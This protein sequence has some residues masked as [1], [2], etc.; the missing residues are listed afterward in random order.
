MEPKTAG[1][2]IRKEVRFAVVM[3]GGVSLAIYINGVVQELFRMVRATAAD[4]GKGDSFLLLPGEKLSGTERVYRK[5][6]RMLGREGEEKGKS[7]RPKDP[8]RTNFV[9]DIL[10]GSS[11]GGINAVYLA[12]A[13]ANGQDIGQLSELWIDEGDIA[14][15]IND[16][17]SRL[18][19]LEPQK[20]PRSLLNGQRMYRKLLEALDGME[21]GKKSEAEAKSPYVE[22]LDLFVTA[23]DF[24]GLPV[25]L[26]LLGKVVEELR[27]RNV[28]QLRYSSKLGEGKIQNDFLAEN[29]PFLAFVARST[30]AFPFAFD[31]IKMTDTGNVLKTMPAYRRQRFD[32]SRWQRFFPVYRQPDQDLPFSERAFVDGGYLDNKPFSYAI[33]ALA[34]RSSR[35]PVDRKLIY[36][37]P[38][39]EHIEDQRRDVPNAI[40]NA[41]AA[42]SS[43]PRYE[44]IREDLQR[45]LHRNRLVE[46]MESINSNVE[47]DVRHGK[48]RKKPVRD[49]RFGEQDLK[50]MIAVE[51]VAYGGYHRL[52]VEAVSDDIVGM[53]SS[54]AEFDVDSDEFFAVR[55]L[56]RAW[57]KSNYTAYLEEDRAKMTENEFLV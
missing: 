52:K 37:E 1:R 21:E 13:L 6:G 4:P 51:G 39:P 10:S 55:Y 44:P 2:E 48:L 27:H 49:E 56:V 16:E 24:Y 45:L 36:V 20:P 11:A 9:V 50:K 7:L 17:G 34:S 8:V 22:A 54:S 38:S 19:G 30:S 26:R 42:L 57:R 46:R 32:W 41:S 15:L 33:D 5:L 40:E 18:N 29:N 43:L 35:V 53:I 25:P 3:Y 14:K 28:Y 23:T 31:P 47:E 12:K